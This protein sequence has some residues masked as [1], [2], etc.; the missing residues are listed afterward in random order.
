MN[1]FN[2][3]INNFIP[4]KSNII[5]WMFVRIISKLSH[6]LHL[7]LKHYSPRFSKRISR[8]KFVNKNWWLGTALGWSTCKFSKKSEEISIECRKKGKLR[9]HWS[10][11]RIQLGFETKVRTIFACLPDYSSK[12]YKRAY[13]V[14]SWSRFVAVFN[15]LLSLSFATFVCIG[16]NSSRIHAILCMNVTCINDD[17]SHGW[18]FFFCFF[19]SWAKHLC[20]QIWN[21]KYNKLNTN[22]TEGRTIVFKWKDK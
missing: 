18:N 20:V 8:L 1:I 16:R 6:P 12:Q 13:D 10:A 15:V 21:W 4:N 14:H 9:L 7:L 2:M 22:T 5:V 11:N 17:M 19:L 3:Y